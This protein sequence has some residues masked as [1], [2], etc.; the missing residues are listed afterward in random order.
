MSLEPEAVT[1]MVPPVGRS[2]PTLAEPEKPSADGA[3]SPA[4]APDSREFTGSVWL[5]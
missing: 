4:G 1:L 5:R 2:W 3:I